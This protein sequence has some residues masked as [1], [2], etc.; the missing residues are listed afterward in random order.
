MKTE[1]SKLR[2]DINMLLD[3]QHRSWPTRAKDFEF[4]LCTVDLKANYP[5]LSIPRLFLNEM[6]LRFSKDLDKELHQWMGAMGNNVVNLAKSKY[7]DEYVVAIS[8]EIECEIDD[9]LKKDAILN[10]AVLLLPRLFNE[11]IDCL[12]TF[13]CQP[14]QLTPTIKMPNRQ[15]L[16][17]KDCSVILDRCTIIEHCSDIDVSLAMACVFASYY[18]FNIEYPV[19]LKNTLLFFEHIV[20]GLSNK[21]CPVTVCRMANTLNKK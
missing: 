9:N 20:F 13:D 19:R 12:V 14:I 3:R 11:S 6:K 4:N 21:E 2:P 8:A 7:K 18:I 1:Y 17:T 15:K 10:A 16:T 5:W